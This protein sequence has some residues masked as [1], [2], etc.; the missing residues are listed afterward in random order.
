MTYVPPDQMRDI[1]NQVSGYYKDNKAS[2]EEKIAEITANRERAMT[3]AGEDDEL[4]DQ[5]MR[6]VLHAAH[7][8]YD[9]VF[10]GFGNEPK[11]PHTDAIDLLH[12]RLPARRRP[13][14]AAHGAQDARVHVQGRHLR[15][16]VGRLLP[17]LHQARL[18]HPPLRED[19]RGQRA[20]AEGAAQALPHHRRR[21][22]PAVHRLHDRVPRHMAQ[23]SRER[24]LLGLAGRRRGVLSAAR[25][26]AEAAR[27]AVRRQDDLHELE[28]DGDQR[29]PRSV[30]DA[31]P[32]RTCAIARCGRST[33]SGITSAAT[34]TACTDTCRP[35]AAASSACSATRR[36][37]RSPS[38]MRTKSPG[39]R[40]TSPARCSSRTSCR[41]TS[42]SP[43]GGFYDTPEGHDGLGRLAQRQ[44][45]VKENAVA[46]M[47]LHPPRPPHARRGVRA[48]RARRPR[49]VRARRR[50]AGLLRRRLREGRRPAAEPGRRGEDRGSS[51]RCGRA[52]PAQRRAGAGRA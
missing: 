35:T 48:R 39:G 15:P 24:L 40:R 32:A 41:T 14:F 51:R 23:R 27:S 50:I 20:A 42:A 16:G 25:R 30:V 37:W 43:N 17:L 34:T 47:A 49:A 31:R 7:D 10:G 1:L 9:P 3:A 5:I 21:R 13:R 6:D 8:A 4:S 45:P 29:L 12:P 2:I 19:A 46:A 44:K 26:T 28:R 22:A 36:G 11:F 38:S 52:R 33:S 18:E